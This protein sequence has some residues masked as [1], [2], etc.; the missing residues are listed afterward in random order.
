MRQIH[1]QAAYS[2]I[3]AI[4]AGCAAA[5][6]AAALWAAVPARGQERTSLTADAGMTAPSRDAAALAALGLDLAAL[7]QADDATLLWR[8]VRELVL[9]G[10]V[11]EPTQQR[12][13]RRVWLADPETRHSSFVDSPAN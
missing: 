4:A 10:K 9:P 8:A 12:I 2:R 13:L 3:P 5:A 6:L 11:S 1:A 7:E